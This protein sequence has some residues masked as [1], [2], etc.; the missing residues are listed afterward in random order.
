[1]SSVCSF[2]QHYFGS[3]E[4]KMALAIGLNV[5]YGISKFGG[6]KIQN[7]SSGMLINWCL[8]GHSCFG[9]IGLNSIKLEPTLQQRWFSP[10][11][12]Y[13][14]LSFSDGWKRPWSFTELL[15]GFYARNVFMET[16]ESSE[17]YAQVLLQVATQCGALRVLSLFDSSWKPRTG[18]AVYISTIK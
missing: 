6:V 2:N 7:S 3:G 12:W 18:I 8:T 4:Q 10:T 1:M 5:R 11:F 17:K 15:Q 13:Q 16:R 9:T 14:I